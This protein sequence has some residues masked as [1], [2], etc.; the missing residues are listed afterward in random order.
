M[1]VIAERVRT[2]HDCFTFLRLFPRHFPSTRTHLRG[3]A[4]KDQKQRKIK[5]IS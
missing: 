2:A 1:D 5:R 3:W 4:R